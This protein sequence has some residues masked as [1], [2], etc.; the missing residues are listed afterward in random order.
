MDEAE[1]VGG[2]MVVGRVNM[3]YARRIAR[4]AGFRREPRHGDSA[5]RLR[6][7]RAKPKNA[8]S[9]EAE[10]HDDQGPQRAPVPA[11]S[12]AFRPGAHHAVVMMIVSSATGSCALRSEPEFAQDRGT[13]AVEIG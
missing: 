10:Q 8:R 12:A 4:D 7:R 11:Y 13:V 6:Q 5:G 9:G 1:R 2:V 3:R